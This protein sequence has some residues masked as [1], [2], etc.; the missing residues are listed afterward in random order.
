M[1]SLWPRKKSAAA[2]GAW[3]SA[4]VPAMARYGG[5][6][7]MAC[8][9]L[10]YGAL[11]VWQDGGRWKRIGVW[12]SLLLPAKVA[13]EFFNRSSLLPHG[14]QPLFITMPESHAPKPCSIFKK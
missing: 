12:I 10:F 4:G 9:I 6:S 14:T 13:L 2:I 8:G 11:T 7:G 1:R 5:M 3:M